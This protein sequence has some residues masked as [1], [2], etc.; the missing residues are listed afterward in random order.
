MS[1]TRPILALV[2]LKIAIL[3]YFMFVNDLI[4]QQSPVDSGL[5]TIKRI[6]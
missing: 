2:R 3:S 1:F 6:L 5:Q 4:T